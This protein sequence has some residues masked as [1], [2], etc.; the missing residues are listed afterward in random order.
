VLRGLVAKHDYGT[1]LL[2]TEHSLHLR[3][4]A[5]G[6]RAA[7]YR[8]PVRALLLA[9]FRLL[10]REGYRQAGLIT[11]GSGY[12]RRW[13]I[14]CGADPA[15]IRVV[16]Q[17]TE[18]A[19]GPAAGPEPLAPTLAWSGPIDPNGGLATMLRAFA[20]VREQLPQAVLR[21]HGEV[22]VGAG[23]YARRCREL[24]R[25][26]A[27]HQ[28][29]AVVFEDSAALPADVHRRAGVLVFSGTSGA[30]PR[31]L[32]EAMLSGR[33][34][35]ATDTGAAR[36]VVGPS[37]LLVPAEDPRAL[38]AACLALLSDGDRRTRLGNAG[39]LRA[40]ELYA[41]EPAATAFRGLYLELVSGWPGP[42]PGRPGSVSTPVARQ[43][44]GRPAD[45]W[46][47][48]DAQAKGPCSREAVPV[49]AG[50]G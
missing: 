24:A 23:A 49:E 3:E 47:A 27:P 36:E 17:G 33:P 6:Y 37:G 13:Q 39:R 12:D 42:C 43:P 21:I 26:I 44:F 16:Y 41:V 22:P 25:L 30:A 19:D 50:A 15:A 4:R 10:A 11:P 7:P 46:L 5:R 8:A 48:A 35:V 14:H 38:A 1:P 2:I 28:R 40:Q 34:V 9:F 32:A 18:R 20:E 31:L 29:D 45:Y